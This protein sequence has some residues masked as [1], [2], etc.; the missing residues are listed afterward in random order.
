MSQTLVHENPRELIGQPPAG[1]RIRI[2]KQKTLDLSRGIRPNVE[3][4]DQKVT[5]KVFIVGDVLP[6]TVR[7]FTPYQRTPRTRA[8]P[9]FSLSQLLELPFDF[10]PDVNPDEGPV[11]VEK[12]VGPGCYVLLTSKLSGSIVGLY[13][14]SQDPVQVIWVS[15][16]WLEALDANFEAPPDSQFHPDS[17]AP[18]QQAILVG[19]GWDTSA[20][21]MGQN[22]AWIT[23]H[24]QYWRLA[25]LTCS[26][27]PK[28][29]RTLSYVRE[30][31]RLDSTTDQEQVQMSLNL[32]LSASASFGWATLSAS[33]SASFSDSRTTTHTTS[34]TTK[35]VTAVEQ[36][37]ENPSTAPLTILEWQL[38][39][40]FL[41]VPSG[42]PPAV[43]ETV[44]P[45]SVMRTHPV[46]VHPII[47]ALPPSR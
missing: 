42:K 7:F 22:P 47:T 8:V 27:A 15:Q 45:V 34:I 4:Y 14:L 44:Q 16:S 40:R 21:V 5:F 35:S 10:D 2:D 29:K 37:L 9:G 46:N 17:L 39:D 32:S 25:G 33:L 28:E 23:I 38:V 30:V 26:L 43:L 18:S 31:G 11:N 20:F 1:K 19:L 13:K 24:E 3:K 36:L 12:T 6:L 41:V